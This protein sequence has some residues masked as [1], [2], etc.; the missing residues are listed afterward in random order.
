MSS[1][2]TLLLATSVAAPATPGPLSD[3]V[4]TLNGVSM[5]DTVEVDGHTLV[6]NGMALRKKFVVKVYVAG[7]YL[8]EKSSD[9]DHIL[10]ADSPRRIVLHFVRGVGKEKMC[11]AW[12]ESLENNSPNAGPELKQQFATLCSYMDDIGKDQEFVFTYVPEQGTSIEV[13]K[14][15]KG[16]LEGKEFADAL[17]KS[18]IGPKPGPGEDFKKKILG[19]S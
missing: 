13:N 7:L 1:L 11:G 18:W 2:L 3:S 6:L 15:V 16:S 4:Q 10:S 14:V 17:F 12:D 8:E 19:A 5:P 9:A